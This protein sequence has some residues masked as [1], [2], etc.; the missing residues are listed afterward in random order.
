MR[1]FFHRSSKAGEKDSPRDLTK[2]EGRKRAVRSTKERKPRLMAGSRVMGKRL[3]SFQCVAMFCFTFV[4]QFLYF[5]SSHFL[6]NS[7]PRPNPINR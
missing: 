6:R 3:S 1:V 5:S 4:L 7:L 2:E